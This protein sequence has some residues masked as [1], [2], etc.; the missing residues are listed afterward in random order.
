MEEEKSLEPQDA[1]VAPGDG[2]GPAPAPADS[3]LPEAIARELEALRAKAAELDGLRKK[4]KE[5]DEFLAL[6]QRVQADFLNY[7]KRMDG[8]KERWSKFL[9]ADLFRDLIPAV[10]ALDACAAMAA[11]GGDPKAHVEGFLIAQK[12]LVRILEKN[13]LKAIAPAEGAFDPAQ[14]EA[15][16]FVESADGEENG[17]GELMRKGYRLHERVLRPAQVRLVRKPQPPE[18][19][20]T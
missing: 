7:Q 20:A 18:A 14:H 17:V 3:V 2:G 9:V 11:K 5:R 6:A 10:D 8:E 1:G 13:G 15:V 19:P 12:E 4:A 16:G